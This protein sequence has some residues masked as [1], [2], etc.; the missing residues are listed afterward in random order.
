MALVHGL[1]CV[2]YREIKRKESFYQKESVYTFKTSRK[3]AHLIRDYALQ[4]C[5]Y[6]D[7]FIY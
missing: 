4:N 3:I 5:K 2:G 1:V 6:M 7:K